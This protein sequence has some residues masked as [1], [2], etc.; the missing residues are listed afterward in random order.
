MKRP[1]I[2]IPKGSK[3]TRIWFLDQPATRLHHSERLWY[4]FPRSV[5]ELTEDF[6]FG[7]TV[8]GKKYLIVVRRGFLTDFASTPN[9]IHVFFPPQN[10]K[11]NKSVLG[12][13]CGYGCELFPRWFLD[14]LLREAMSVEGSSTELRYTFWHFVRNWGWLTYLGHTERSVRDARDYID[15]IT[16]D[17]A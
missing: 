10:A 4:V 1:L 12:H 13:D 14:L 17:A 9:L 5:F 2:H 7:F 8:N 16:E 11:W 6:V 3:P 15:I